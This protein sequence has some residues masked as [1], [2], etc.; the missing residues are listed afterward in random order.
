MGVLL[1]SGH[2]RRL[3]EAF[4]GL[5]PVVFSGA[6]LALGVV[7]GWMIVRLPP[8]TLLGMLAALAVV[9]GSL[10]E[11]L[12][13]LGAALVTG[14]LRAWL[15]IQSPG[16]APQV[17]QVLLV[18]TLVAWVTRGL[19]QR[20]LRLWLPN[21]AV[22][23]GGFVF[24]GMLSLWGGSDLEAGVT[25]VLKWLQVLVV[26]AVVWDRL[27]RMGKRAALL[28]A[29]GVVAGAALQAALGVWQFVGGGTV[30]KEF[31]I[32]EGFYRAYG[33]FQQPNPYAGF[34]GLTGAFVVGSAFG[35]TVDAVRQRQMGARLWILVSMWA[36]AALL[37]A[38]LVASWS[39]GGWMGFAAALILSVAL[40]PRRRVIGVGLIALVVG[41]GTVLF[42][43]GRLPAVLLERLTG[44]TAYLQFTD[45]RG[46]GITDENF[47]VVERMAHW[48]AALSMWR[49]RFWLGVGLGGYEAAY[50]THRLIAWV[51]PL[52]H[53][54]NFYLN[55]LAEVGVIGTL[56]FLSW[57][58]V[59]AWGL[60]WTLNHAQG[61]LG[62]LT[63]GLIGAWVHL[64]IHS[65]VDH[66]VVNNVHL[67]L[68]VLLALSAWVFSEVRW[69][70]GA[71][72]DMP[73]ISRPGR[74]S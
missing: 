9:I 42:I 71:G 52:G 3:D 67:H 60:L 51:L 14:P 23:L 16:L 63:L 26:C 61:A 12:V 36:L 29:G 44:F 72:R 46:I 56:A 54:H 18:W 37:V 59:L 2:A 10:A 73:L 17:G 41:L 68:G 62:A 27:M 6:L 69:Q 43:T 31:A 8:L 57:G 30:V 21:L 24:V 65:L 58:L 11:P 70:C 15:E 47:A 19:W 38:G 34:V 20:D 50:P 13:G 4:E 32:R 74:L 35:M 55:L 33:T 22:P 49:A 5:R 45:V 1:S 7:A 53:A 64:A 28:A 66:L 25:E 48:Q 39:R 40:V